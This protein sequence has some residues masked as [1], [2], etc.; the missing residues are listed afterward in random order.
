MEILARLTKK[1]PKLNRL[2]TGYYQHVEKGLRMDTL[3]SVIMPCYKAENTFK[4]AIAS[5]ICQSHENWECIVVDDGPSNA[6]GNLVS[7]IGDSRIKYYR[8]NHRQGRG[9]ARNF[10]LSL[11]RG[12]FVAFVDA[13]DWIYPNK[14]HRQLE[15]FQNFR[16]IVLVATGMAVIG[17][18]NEI[19]GSRTMSDKTGAQ[20]QSPIRKIRHISANFPT[21]MIESNAIKKVEFDS[22]L[23]GGEDH[24]MLW[25]LLK[26]H[27]HFILPELLY[28]YNDLNDN[29]YEKIRHR[30][31]YQRK[32]LRKSINE[33]P[34][35]SVLLIV[36][37]YL[38]QVIYK[39][40]FI[41]GY[42]ENIILNRN[43]P[44]SEIQIKS[45]F[46]AQD[47]VKSEVEKRSCLRQKIDGNRVS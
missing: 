13:D 43:D 3:V 39:V 40:A 14:L 38:K 10:A 33:R 23:M 30:A 24:D 27:R 20:V 11:V 18:R 21:S 25:R 45:F 42:G 17:H 16:G 12:D 37:S 5:L 28:A 36:E 29:S 6:I 47:V 46:K 26:N 35:E 1:Q 7:E 15:V 31:S 32:R 19:V 34:A 22:T 9:A 4:W 2:S 8:A 41:T 44:P